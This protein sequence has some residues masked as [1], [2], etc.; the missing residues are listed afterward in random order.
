MF[1]NRVKIINYFY[2]LCISSKFNYLLLVFADSK[3]QN[4]K[5]YFHFNEVYYL[6]NFERKKFLELIK[7]K[8]IVI[9]LRMHQKPTGSSRNRGTGFRINNLEE[10]KNCYKEKIQI[11]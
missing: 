5:E 2:T 3:K 6:K 9:N 11:V 8:K 1:R 7:N 4:N 10:L